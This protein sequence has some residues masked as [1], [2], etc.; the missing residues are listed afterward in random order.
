[1]KR[2]L[3]YNTKQR[4][5]VL[6]YII[7]LGNVHVTAAQIICHF[8][9]C[10]IAVGRTTIYRYLDRLINNGKLR[11]YNVE[12]IKGGCYQYIND[13]AETQNHLLL[14]CEDCGE[15]LHLNCDTLN[16]IH[17]HIY[18]EHTFKVNITKTV[19]YGKCD[20]CCHN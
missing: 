17:K 9:K 7:S 20:I 15:L 10:D 6:D 12:G 4:K 16:E 1:M 2:P 5:A 11:K 8:E 13:S 3:S 18:Q 19:F 14:K